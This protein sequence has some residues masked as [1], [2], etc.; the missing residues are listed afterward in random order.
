[1]QPHVITIVVPMEAKPEF[2]SIVR[3]HLTEL[4]RQTRQE[5]GNRFYI[6]HEANDQPGKFIICESWKSQAALDFHM[7]QTYLQ[8]FLKDAETWMTAPIAGTICHPLIPEDARD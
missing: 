6:P 7:S 3:E 2:Y 1:M 5:P 8:R 4:A